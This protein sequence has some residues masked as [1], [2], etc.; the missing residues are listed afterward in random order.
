[1][2]VIA[3]CYDSL[4][5]VLLLIRLSRHSYHK[6]SFVPSIS[7]THSCCILAPKSGPYVISLRDGFSHAVA[8]RYFV[9]AM[10]RLCYKSEKHQHKYK[11][12][13]QQI[14][15]CIYIYTYIHTYA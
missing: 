6:K 8:A 9:F 14:Y 2:S 5:Y 15:M 13:H 4:L 10:A 1:M 3:E 11:Y 12:K 7:V